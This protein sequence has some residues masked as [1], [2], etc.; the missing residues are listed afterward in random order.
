VLAAKLGERVVSTWSW[1][2]HV[3]FEVLVDYARLI[4]AKGSLLSFSE[5]RIVI[6]IQV[7]HRAIFV[8]SWGLNLLCWHAKSVVGFSER[9]F[10]LSSNL[11]L[12][13]ILSC[14]FGILV[15]SRSGQLLALLQT[16]LLS[17]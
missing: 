9:I 12:E 14:N 11:R 3:Q 2:F 5:S 10:A 15:E 4:F 1:I 17:R 8:W 6:L 13:E 16:Q 7:I